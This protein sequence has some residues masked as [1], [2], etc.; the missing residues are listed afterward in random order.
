MEGRALSSAEIDEL[1]EAWTHSEVAQRMS[2]VSARG[3]SRP[4]GRW[5]CSPVMPP[6]NTMTSKSLYQPHGSVKS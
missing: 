3:M 5:S 1:W 2:T 6:E 4:V